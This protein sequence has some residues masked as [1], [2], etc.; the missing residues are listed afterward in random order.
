M[1]Q[2]LGKRIGCST[3]VVASTTRTQGASEGTVTETHR[4]CGL[5]QR[6]AANSQG[7]AGINIPTLLS[8]CSPASGSV[9]HLIYPTSHGA[10]RRLLMLPERAGSPGY[11]A[12]WRR[13]ESGS[14]GQTNLAASY[15]SCIFSLSSHTP[16]P[17]T[18]NEM[19]NSL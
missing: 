2:E 8:A 17:A 1:R 6:D 11:R 15:G 19:I 12:R 14:Q 7:P 3:P 5:Q 13:V 16:S 4:S 18:T 9:L 10:R